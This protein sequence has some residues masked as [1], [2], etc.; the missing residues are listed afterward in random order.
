MKFSITREGRVSPE[1]ILPTFGT[2]AL[3]LLLLL[4]LYLVSGVALTA[5]VTRFLRSSTLATIGGDKEARRG[6]KTSWTMRLMYRWSYLQREARKT[7]R[8]CDSLRGPQL[9]IPFVTW[10]N[11]IS[12][13]SLM[14]E[15][16]LRPV[17]SSSK[18]A[19][20]V[21]M[22]LIAKGAIRWQRR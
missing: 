13:S 22:L 9:T 12:H 5:L 18:G 6:P 4:L 15:I 2:Y 11:S 1:T 17:K 16:V 7:S 21:H 20:F 10:C 14:G 3:V 8:Y 19:P